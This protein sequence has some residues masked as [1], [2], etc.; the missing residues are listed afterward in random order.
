MHYEKIDGIT[1]IFVDK[2]ETEIRMLRAIVKASFELARPM[3]MGWLHFDKDYQLTDNDADQMITLERDTIFKRIAKK[4]GLISRIG[5]MTIVMSEKLGMVQR[6]SRMSI[7]ISMDYVQ[8]RQCKTTI[9]RLEEGH[10]TLKNQNYERDRGTPEPML[11]RAKEILSG[12]QSSG[13]VSTIYMYKGENLTL[14]LKEYGFTRQNGESDWELRKRVFPDLYEKN[15]ITALEF[16]MGQSLAEWN[17]ENKFICA[18]LLVETS[19]KPNRHQLKMFVRGFP[20]DP[21]DV[22]ERCQAVASN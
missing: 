3:S 16:L 7:V 2:G 5:R 1:H 21:L 12:K 19:H 8:G 10:F 14:R 18:S 15:P 9:D 6:T 11:N 20:S 17:E 22:N 4:L 13:F